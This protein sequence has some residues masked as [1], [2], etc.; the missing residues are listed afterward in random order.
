MSLLVAVVVLSIS[1]CSENTES[2]QPVKQ[3]MPNPAF[4]IEIAADGGTSVVSSTPGQAVIIDPDPQ[5]IEIG[6]TGHLFHES[7]LFIVKKAGN[8]II[9]QGFR[10]HETFVDTY[11]QQ[12]Q[13]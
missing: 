2:R 8:K 6:T 13:K 11:R 9:I 4:V 3:V 12:K 1:G 10:Q 5:N 7:M